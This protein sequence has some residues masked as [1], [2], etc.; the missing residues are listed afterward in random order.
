M[1]LSNGRLAGS[2]DNSTTAATLT[3]TGLGNEEYPASGHIC[4][5]GKE[6][7]SFTRSGDA[8]TVTRGQL[9][10]TAHS[11]NAGDRAQ[12]VLYFDGDDVADIIHYLF[13]EHAL[14]CIVR[15]DYRL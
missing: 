5:G 2:I 9:G 13:T 8:L 4:L 1:R 3:P 10:S 6:I 11:H 12:L 15:A 7:V 14:L